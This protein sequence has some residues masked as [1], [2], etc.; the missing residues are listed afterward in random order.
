MKRRKFVFLFVLAALALS[1]SACYFESDDDGLQSWLSNQGMPSSNKVQV[2]SVNGLKVRS[3]EVFLDTVPKSAD[4]I[5][6]FGHQSNLTHDLVLDFAF[7]DSSFMRKFSES[8][9]SGAYLELFWLLPFYTSK[10]VPTESLPAE[11]LEVTFSW[12][13]DLGSGKGFLDSLADIADSVW[14]RDL[15]EWKADGS[16]DT[17]FSTKF[18]A[19]D[20]SFRWK[21]PSGFVEAMKKAR[22]SVHL[23]LR[24]SAPKAKYLYRFY[25]DNSDEF[26]PTLALYSNRTTYIKPSQTPFRMAKVLKN[27]EECPE[28]PV[29]H[30]GVYDSLEIELPPE[31]IL[32]A[33]SDFYGDDFPYAADDGVDVRQTVLHAQLTMARDDSKGENELGL[34]IRVFV[35][36][37]VDSANTVVRRMESYLLNDEVILKDG[38]QNLVF[39]EGD[40]LT[41]QITNGVRDFLNKASDGRSIKLMVRLGPP[42]LQ[43]KDTTYSDYV[44]TW[45]DT[46]KNVNGG[47]SVVV[48]K[49]T[50]LQYFDYYDYARYDFSTA[51]DNPMTLKLWLAS[52]RGDKE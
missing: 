19:S 2:L 28:C 26:S 39:H 51:V 47:D 37:Y 30:A 8:D 7:T 12:K 35:G 14:Y 13:L 27:E 42:Y 36:S 32:K 22:E 46:L 9:S 41:L 10:T 18:V 4:A 21:L 15:M 24:L 11:E 16:A 33:L 48:R 25:G 49:D 20:T 6:L 50:V 23:Q 40:S 44:N 45:N 31:P 29:L 17:V 34:P 1:L 38:F 5:A 3:A 52:K 43:E